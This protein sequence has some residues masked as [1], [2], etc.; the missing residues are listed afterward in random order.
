ML[1]GLNKVFSATFSV[2]ILLIMIG[3]GDTSKSVETNK[4]NE[5]D[6]EVEKQPHFKTTRAVKDWTWEVDA[7][8][9]IDNSGADLRT[10]YYDNIPQEIV[11]FQIFIDAIPGRGFSGAN[12][13][14]VFG[15]DYLIENGTLYK[16]LNDSDWKWKR[17]GSISQEDNKNAG[18]TREI[19]FKNSK[20][21]ATLLSGNEVDIYIESYDKNWKGE[22][23]TIPLKG[24]KINRQVIQEKAD[25]RIFTIGD[26]TVHNSSYGE[27]GWGNQSA[28]GSYMKDKSHLFNLGRSG[29]S[30]Q[31]FKSQKWAYAKEIIQSNNANGKGY[32]LIQ[33]GHNDEHEGGTSTSV[34]YRELASYVD[35]A[36][37]H[38]LTAV[39]ITPVERRD[40]RYGRDNRKTHNTDK[41]DYAQVV[42]DL[43]DDK[44][45]LLLDLQDKSWNEY[46][47]Y[48]TTADINADLAY[49]DKTH[50]SKSGARIVS[51]WVRELICQ[52]SDD[53]LCAQFR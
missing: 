29:S 53:R 28:L 18:A 16:S 13:W 25:A 14:E 9:T 2:A 8:I 11:N 23:Y 24:I 52:S 12:G 26:S 49:D 36:R 19:A 4:Y 15:A 35:W 41:G 32:L 42:R 10:Y 22:Y 31:S 27:M 44:S 3:C 48:D 21:L 6:K 40:K 47:T 34:F 30:S 46:N 51:G 5:K 43:A 38:H 33:F 1:S 7:Q 39:L 20:L 17:L 50:F 37:A 45:V